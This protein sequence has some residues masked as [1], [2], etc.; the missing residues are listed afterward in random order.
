MHLIHHGR[1]TKTDITIVER[2]LTFSRIIDSKL[3]TIN[4][5]ITQQTTVLQLEKIISNACE[6]D[7]EMFS[8]VAEHSLNEDELRIG[9][10]D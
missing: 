10:D 2:H 3:A 4:K 5:T 9:R 1:N 6:L 7:N 8:L